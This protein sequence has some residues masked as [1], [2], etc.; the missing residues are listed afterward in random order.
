MIGVLAATLL[1]IGLAGITTQLLGIVGLM[2]AGGYLYNGW[3]DPSSAPNN[4]YRRN[5]P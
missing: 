1:R 4:F 5:T 2:L 3:Q